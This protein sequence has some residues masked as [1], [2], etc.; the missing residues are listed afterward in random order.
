MPAAVTFL[1]STAFT[2]GSTAVSWGTVLA[3]T[4]AVSSTVYSQV[5]AAQQR[6]AIEAIQAR[7]RGFGISSREPAAV[8]RIIYGVQ[9]VGGTIVDIRS[10]GD[11]NKY[12]HQVIVLA[13]HEVSAIGDLY[14]DDRLVPVNESGAAN[15]GRYFVPDKFGSAAIR[16]PGA[17]EKVLIQRGY[18]L[19]RIRKHL[20][21]AD[22][23][24]DSALVS[25]SGGRWSSE[26]RL[27]GMA[28]VYVRFEF[29]EKKFSGVPNVS[30]MVEGKKV[31]DPRTGL[32]AFSR[33][34]A[35]CWLDYM[36]D[37]TY[38][39]GCGL[40]EID[41]ASVIAAAN[42]CDE[43]VALATGG[44]EPRYTC[45]GVI[46][47]SE[48]PVSIIEMLLSSMAGWAVYTG[49]YW[50]IRAGAHQLVPAADLTLGDVRGEIVVQTADSRRDTC[51]GVKGTFISALNKWQPADY[52]PVSSATYMQE[53][54]ERIWRD[55]EL[56]FTT[57]ATTAQRLAKIE[58][59]RTRRDTTVTLPLNLKGM[60]I[61]AGDL[62]TLTVDRYGWNQ[63]L[64]E[65]TAWKFAVDDSGIDAGSASGEASGPVL[66]VDVEL[67]A[68]D[69]AAW[70]WSPNDATEAE[71]A[72][73][74]SLLD[75]E[76]ALSAPDNVVR[77]SIDGLRLTWLPIATGYIL[78]YRIRRQSGDRTT[79]AD[80]IPVHEGLVTETTYELPS[81]PPG[82]CTLLIKAVAFNGLESD[83]PAIIQTEIGDP[84]VENVLETWD[85]Q[86]GGF[87]GTRYS[88]TLSSGALIADGTTAMWAADANT[89]MWTSSATL[90]WGAA[91]YEAM[92]Y[93]F[94]VTTAQAL[95]GLRLTLETDITGDAHFIEY[96]EASTNLMWNAVTTTPMWTV[97]NENAPMWTVGPWMVWLGELSLKASGS[98]DFRV[99][100]DAGPVRGRI[101]ALKAI[102]DVRD[103]VQPADDIAIVSGGTRLPLARDFTVIKSVQLTLQDDGGTAR[104]ARVLDKDAAFGPLVKCYDSAGTAVAGSVDAIIQGY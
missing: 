46:E 3:V 9:R 81:L 36:T 8:R 51:N 83:S 23:V 27:R 34:P 45:D 80:A 89:A 25:E 95:E 97:D 101:D 15:S 21:T 66:G 79:W 22:Q 91:L 71:A 31:F 100:C 72:P 17:G 92:A 87:T 24:A 73:E 78:G 84:I 65:V 59:E 52:P 20:G 19:V 11:K 39:L 1:A 41:L 102:V 74:T 26:H 86:A 33:N 53:D 64:F 75:A 7:S 30:V 82:P 35:L 103:I 77:F 94:R 93:E 62:V 55:L 54:G 85:E 69:A 29:D 42:I 96:R 70:E 61:K 88:C 57:S 13:A 67:R 37:Q 4:A 99:T 63:K 60:R 16:G 68:T 10:S 12:H 40:D 104:T 47:T 48:T 50:H 6:K 43:P 56:P 14:L 2:V 28:Y 38:G 32:T 98:Y 58:M 44:T 76:D 90:M 18:G 49:G 5:Q